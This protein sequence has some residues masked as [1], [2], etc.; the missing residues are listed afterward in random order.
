MMKT[1]KSPKVWGDIFNISYNP[2]IKKNAVTFIL[3]KTM[4]KDI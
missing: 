2:D 1:L 4:D 3:L